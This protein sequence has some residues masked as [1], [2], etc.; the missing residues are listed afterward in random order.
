MMQ[1]VL[2]VLKADSFGRVEIVQAEQ[3]KQV[4][5]VA[6]GGRIPGSALTAR[7]LG[8]RKEKILKRLSHITG[9]PRGAG[10][11]RRAVLS[12]L[13]RGIATLFN[14]LSPLLLFNDQGDCLAAKLR[15]GNV[16]SANGWE[17]LLLPEIER[18]Q[19]QGIEVAFRGDAAFAKP[20]IYESVE[21]RERRLFGGM[22]QRIVTLP[23]P[24]G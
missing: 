12:I 11:R 15:P 14:L 24:A 6:C 7:M 3:G 9:L 13:Y 23:V 16:H 19:A 21:K 20:E 10:T 22:L 17:E 4:R 1:T 18:Q 8:R 5:R 2:R